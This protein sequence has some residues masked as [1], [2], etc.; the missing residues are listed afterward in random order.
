MKLIIIR[1]HISD[2]SKFCDG[3]AFLPV[4]EREDHKGHKYLHHAACCMCKGNG[5]HPRWITL[6]ELADLVDK[7][8]LL[9]PKEPD[10]AELARIIPISKYQDSR[11][12]AGI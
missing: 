4:G 9:D 1:I 2:Y 8:A 6:Q 10:Y 12:A 3:D 11:E 7:I 5:R